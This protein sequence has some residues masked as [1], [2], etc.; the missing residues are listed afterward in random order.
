[1]LSS[2]LFQLEGLTFTD[3]CKIARVSR[4]VAGDLRVHKRRGCLEEEAGSCI[5]MMMT[6]APF[7][8]WG[9]GCLLKAGVVKAGSHPTS[10]LG[11]DRRY[12]PERGLASQTSDSFSSWLCSRRFGSDTNPIYGVLSHHRA[13]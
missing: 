8:S 4:R 7:H 2:T 3:S 1:M 9:P 13:G 6:W 5:D 12:I 11:V 10:V